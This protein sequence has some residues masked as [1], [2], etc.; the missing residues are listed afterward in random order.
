VS[1]AREFWIGEL[2]EGDT[3]ICVSTEPIAEPINKTN[4]KGW[5]NIW[6]VIEK[7]DYDA[8]LVEAKKLRDALKWYLKDPQ[9]NC[10]TLPQK[11]ITEFDEYIESL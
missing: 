5:N 3:D 9:Q 6:H 10:V 2:D 8:L 1:K 11:A 4:G 7:S